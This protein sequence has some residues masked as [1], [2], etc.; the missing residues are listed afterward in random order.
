MGRGHTLAQRWLRQRALV[1]QGTSRFFS[2]G[3][4]PCDSGVSSVFFRVWGPDLVPCFR[5]GLVASPSALGGF[6]VRPVS[7]VCFGFV[8]FLLLPCSCILHLLSLG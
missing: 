7:A 2:F 5:F 8:F 1:L 4:F 6:C 3:V